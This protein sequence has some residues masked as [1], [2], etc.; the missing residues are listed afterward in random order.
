[1]KTTRNTPP[2]VLIIAANDPS[3]GAG[4]VADI[5]TVSHH[6]CQPACVLTALTVQD[7]VNVQRIEAVTAE[8]LL[9]QAEPI[10]AD[11][12]VAAIK[13][14]LIG[15]TANIT[16]LAT[17]LKKWRDIPVVL[18]PILRAGGGKP[19]ASQDMAAHM[20]QEL[21]PLTTLLTP[22]IHELLSLAGCS[23]IPEAVEKLAAAGLEW[24]LLTTT[25][26]T[27]PLSSEVTNQLFCQGQ[28]VASW[29]WPRLPHTYHGSGCTLA[30]AAASAIALAPNAPEQILNAAY[31]AQAF[32]WQSLAAGCQ[33]GQGQWH[34]NRRFTTP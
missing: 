6:Q 17:L 19:L 18:D 8:L 13:I 28:A 29:R 33:L 23:E 22:N 24:L 2:V 32:T 3:G 5:E 9:A 7:S 31:R 20:V 25:D 1:M 11:M 30:A 12:P 34:P 27:D 26:E 16:A 15:S 21:L 10:L 14:G 4:I